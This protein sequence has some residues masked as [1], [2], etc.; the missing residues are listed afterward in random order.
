MVHLSTSL[1][2]RNVDRLSALFS[3]S[4]VIVAYLRSQAYGLLVSC[5]E[6]T[7]LPILEIYMQNEPKF[8]ERKS[9]GNRK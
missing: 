6:G 2:T 8:P 1:M 9:S 5:V 3:P 7:Q 4:S